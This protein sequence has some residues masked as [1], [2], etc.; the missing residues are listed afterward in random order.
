MDLR[1][2]DKELRVLSML[3]ETEAPVTSCYLN[4]GDGPAGYRNELDERVRTVTCRLKGA[5]R[6]DFQESWQSIE[7]FLA[8]SVLPNAKGIALFSRAGQDPFFLPLQFRVP[9]PN[10]IA[11]GPTPHILRLAE[12]RSTYDRCAVMVLMQRNVRILE[13]NGGTVTEG[14]WEERSEPPRSRHRWSR[15]HIQDYNREQER[16]LMAGRIRLLRRVMSRGGYKHL[17]L[18]GNRSAISRVRNM[19]PTHLRNRVIALVPAAAT[20][21]SHD[22]AAAALSALADYRE[23]RARAIVGTL[24]ASLGGLGGAVAGTRGSLRALVDGQADVLIITRGYE[25]GFGWV[26]PVCGEMGS[27]GSAPGAWPHCGHRDI[28]WVDIKEEMARRAERRGCRL[29]VL[30]SDDAADLGSGVGCLL[31]SRRVPRNC[32]GADE[33]RAL[34]T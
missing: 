12:L 9:L 20:S 23:T 10:W 14:T 15:D 2:L 13:V 16:R 30:A 3:P 33:R 19:L 11:A 22:L 24:K 27:V 18:A 5:E 6:Q 29:E 4:I 7:M 32:V 34:P 28:R 21:L 17:I 31:R 8:G 25:P 1:K 26:C